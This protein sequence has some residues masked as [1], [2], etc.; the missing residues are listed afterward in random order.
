[1]QLPFVRTFPYRSDETPISGCAFSS[2]S[3][4]GCVFSVINGGFSDVVAVCTVPPA[5]QSPGFSP[6]RC[7]QR[8]SG[9]GSS[10]LC[11]NLPPSVPG[12]LR[13]LLVKPVFQRLPAASDVGTGGLPWVR[14]T[15]SPHPVRLRRDLSRD[16]LR[17]LGLDTGARSHRSARSTPLCHIAGSLFATYAG[18]TSLYA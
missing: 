10:V 16:A 9:P 5:L 7:Y 15:A 8:F 13:G 3:R 14:P 17:G 12:S 11:A 1:M 18:F 2:V 4:L 6:P